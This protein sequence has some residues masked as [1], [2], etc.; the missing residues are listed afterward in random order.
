MTLLAKSHKLFLSIFQLSCIGN[1][2]YAFDGLRSSARASQQQQQANRCNKTFHDLLLN[3]RHTTPV[4]CCGAGPLSVICTMPK[5]TTYKAVPSGENLTE[6]GRS[7][8]PPFNHVAGPFLL[9]SFTAKSRMTP[10]STFT[11]T[12]LK[13]T[14]DNTF[15][16]LGAMS[17]NRATNASPLKPN[18]S[19][20]E[21][22]NPFAD[23]CT[24]KIATGCGG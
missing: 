17:P 14:G 20:R 2:F 11:R 24:P 19:L 15:P 13:P 16:T 18:L 5:S 21:K 6:T 23:E 7:S 12:T 3:I 4:F 9:P 10:F 22:S 1:K 8:P